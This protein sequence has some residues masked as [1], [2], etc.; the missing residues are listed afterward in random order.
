MKRAHDEQATL[1]LVFVGHGGVE[2]DDFYLLAKDS[3]FPDSRGAVLIGQRVKE[4]LRRYSALDGL[5]LLVDA[6]HSG[7]AAEQAGRQWLE[8]MR[9]SRRRFELLTA[10]DEGLAFGACMVRSV[11]RMIRTGE[12][13]LGERIHCLD[14]KRRLGDLCHYQ[15]AVHLTYDGSR[16][17]AEQDASLWIAVNAAPAW[18]SA[19]VAGT[20]AMAEIERLTRFYQPTRGLVDLKTVIAAGSRCVVLAGPRGS[21]K[22]TTIAALTKPG[23]DVDTS[24]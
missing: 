13:D 12:P 4:L 23:A 18:R 22:S 16:E 19:A 1:F 24:P 5:V 14:L 6:C 15:V 3:E 20:G 2:G 7:L 21:G 9:R 11:T 10:T 8:P 17:I